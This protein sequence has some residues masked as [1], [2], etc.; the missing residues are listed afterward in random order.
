MVDMAL[1]IGLNVHQAGAIATASGIGGPE[2][3]ASFPIEI[4]FPD[5]G[6]AGFLGRMRA[7][8]SFEREFESSEIERG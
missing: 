5:L 2:E 4:V 3:I 7:T 8:F 1:L 6:H